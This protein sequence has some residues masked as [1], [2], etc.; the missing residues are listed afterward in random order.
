MNKKVISGLLL[1]SLSA[2]SALAQVQ[3]V[4][5]NKDIPSKKVVDLYQMMSSN[6]PKNLK[7]MARLKDHEIHLRWSE[8]ASLA[9][10]VFAM[11]TSLRGWIG[12]TWLHCLS[13]QQK[14]KKDV[15]TLERA[16]GTLQGNKHLF[17][18]GPWAADLSSSYLTLKLEHLDD[19]VGKKLGKSSD[20]EELLTGPFELSKDQKSKIYS[21]LADIALN[22]NDFSQAKF[23]FEEAQSYKDT[24]YIQDRLDF[25]ERTN[26]K[27]DAAIAGSAD[28][29]PVSKTVVVDPEINLELK[30]Q[31]DLK[32]GDP[33]AAVKSAV[34]L[35]NQYPGSSQAKRV[36]D[37]PLEIYNTLSDEFKTRAL[38]EM[39]EADS[40]RLLEWAQS[41]H[42]RGDYSASLH[43]ASKYLEK[44][45]GAE[46]TTSAHWIV[47]RSAHFA[48]NYDLA[49]EHFQK[50]ITF[51]NGSD[52][53][54]EALLRAGLIYYRKKDFLTATSHF[55]R[56]L[57]QEKEKYDLNAQYWLVRSLQALKAERAK[58][59]AEKL[60]QR[61][62][63][64]YYGLRLRA[65]SQ[66]G[67]LKW[68]DVKE[69]PQITAENFYLV[70]K[71]K[72]TWKRFNILS[73]A[74]WVVEAHYEIPQLPFV[75]DPTL[76]IKLAEKMA[77]R[78]QF[79]T[80][81]RWTNEALEAAPVLR[82][83]QFIKFAYPKVFDEVYKKEGER[84]GIH[85]SLLRSLTRQE[86]G[87]HLQAVSTSNAL[88]LMQM[89]PPTAQEVA[90][91]LSLRIEIPEDMFRPEINIPMGSSYVAQ[92]LVQFQNNVPFALA[93]YN[94]GPHRL[95]IWMNGRSEVS[96]LVTRPSSEVLDEV[97]FDE[98]PWTETSFYVKAI[99]RNVLLYRLVEDREI[100]LK[101]VLWQDLLYKKAK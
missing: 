72:D 10:S 33:I 84:Y 90:R 50:L 59:A 79:F 43:F 99:L 3:M 77:E 91:K 13:K 76:K 24:S 47:G 57:Q 36:K 34:T 37:K 65:E 14:K 83:E 7:P 28:L 46:K 98:L 8:C 29:S 101:P 56:L 6:E 70:G 26:K 11:N 93:A 41:L 22:K 86:S 39:S 32:R 61:Y 94:A 88:G 58:E 35:L 42:R 54:S 78:L 96:D 64:S 60:I 23:F 62:P 5:V 45:P 97:W 30:I 80:A 15:A 17:N 55:D 9:P 69:K 71:Q 73:D 53:S 4:H 66:S 31:Q 81:I 21:L 51:H 2:T 82:Q 18:E 1:C 40:I 16:L 12:L 87:F 52:E 95:K 75:K 25:I 44:N 19:L 48:G 20:L 68:P 92:M 63:F 74:G 27:T 89:I 38:A 100:S 67:K 85:P 49:L